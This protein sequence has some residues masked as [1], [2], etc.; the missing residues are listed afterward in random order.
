MVTATH[1]VRLITLPY[2]VNCTTKTIHYSRDSIDPYVHER[3]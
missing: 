1:T 2:P 3:E